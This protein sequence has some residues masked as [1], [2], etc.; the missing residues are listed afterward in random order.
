MRVRVPQMSFLKGGQ[1]P[2]ITTGPGS[3]CYRSVSV[4]MWPSIDL[5][6]L[7]PAY[8]WSGIDPLLFWM[9]FYRSEMQEALI[10]TV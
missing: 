5:Q 1:T 7:L 2:I 4:R 3:I 6:G 10:F 9:E 8:R